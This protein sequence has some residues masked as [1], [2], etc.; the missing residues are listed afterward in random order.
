MVSFYDCS[1]SVSPC[2]HV[3]TVTMGHL[4]KESDFKVNSIPKQKMNNRLCEAEDPL[5][6]S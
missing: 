6:H 3:S 2:I 5:Y 1:M 4:D